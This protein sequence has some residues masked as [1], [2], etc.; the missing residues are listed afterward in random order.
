MTVE[1]T[2]EL[3]RLIRDRIKHLEKEAVSSKN[4]Q[5]IDQTVYGYKELLYELID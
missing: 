4:K 1:E 2:K 3:R 5:D